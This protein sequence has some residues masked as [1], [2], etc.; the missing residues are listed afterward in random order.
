MLDPRAGGDGEGEAE[1]G[2]QVGHH[3]V[4]M[5][6]RPAPF[7]SPQIVAGAGRSGVLLQQMD[8]LPPT[9]QRHEIGVEPAP[10]RQAKTAA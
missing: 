2:V 8:R 10:D 1:A 6:R 4:G 3:H 5:D 9:Q 7:V